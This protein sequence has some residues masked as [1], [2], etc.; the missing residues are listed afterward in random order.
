MR[1][2]IRFWDDPLAAE[3]VEIY[4]LSEPSLGEAIKRASA[5]KVSLRARYGS[6]AGYTVEDEL[7]HTILIDPGS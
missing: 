2:L 4:V 7:G 6:R 5:T 1:Y 3:R